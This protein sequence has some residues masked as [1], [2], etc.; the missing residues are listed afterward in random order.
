MKKALLATLALALL[1]PSCA[2]FNAQTPWATVGT[3]TG[4]KVVLYRDI[5][6]PGGGENTTIA[7]IRVEEEQA[8]KLKD[9]TR[10]AV[11]IFGG[12]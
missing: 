2:K 12:E 11:K 8:D 7:T 6:L 10:E 3:Q 1:L 4:N 9:V 5:D